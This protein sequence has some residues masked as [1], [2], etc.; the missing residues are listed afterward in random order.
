LVNFH[1]VSL[2]FAVHN[3]ISFQSFIIGFYE[4]L[5]NKHS[6]LY[7]IASP[8]M[9]MERSNES[10]PNWVVHG[11]LETRWDGIDIKLT[12]LKIGLMTCFTYWE[13]VLQADMPK[14]Q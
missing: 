4:T 8:L 7:T 9:G 14:V 12:L 6:E 1:S 5:S 13:N 3:L 2:F 10:P 11:W